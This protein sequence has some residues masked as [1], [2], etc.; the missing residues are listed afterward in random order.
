MRVIAICGSPRSGNMEFILKRILINAEK[1]GLDTDFVMLKSKS[2]EFC[3]GCLTCDSTGLCN[4][5]DDMQIIYSKLEES[6]I[7]IFGSPIYF[8]SVTGMMKNF[9]DRLNLF[10]TT[11]KLK[12]KK[13]ASICVGQSGSASSMKVINYFEY[14]SNELGL[15]PIG[16]LSFEAKES[17][18]VENNSEKVS[19]IDQFAESVFS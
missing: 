13:F 9:I 11:K 5:K 4:I 7:I 12:G 1:K 10:Y 8:D 15:V 14:I 18:E 2:I 19:Q 17:N 3:N 6:D 16:D